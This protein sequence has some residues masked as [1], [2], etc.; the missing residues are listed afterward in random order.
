MNMDE[1]T[2]S[3]AEPR[4]EA[5][6][7]PA[8][9][10]EALPA[11]LRGERA[12][13]K[14]AD[15]PALAKS[16]LELDRFRGRAVVPPG[17]DATP[18]DRA[19]FY[20]RMGRPKEAKDYR[21]EMEGVEVQD[22]AVLEQYLA[23]FHE[24]GLTDA[25]VSALSRFEAGRV[26]AAGEAR[27][28]AVAEQWTSLEAEW[29]GERDAQLGHARRAASALGLEREELDRIADASGNPLGLMRALVKLGR[30]FAEDQAPG[31]VARDGGEGADAIQ[32]RID[33]LQSG[34]L[35]QTQ[36]AQ[37]HREVQALYRKLY[38]AEE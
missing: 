25:Q 24:M 13:E 30:G 23:T 15:V 3:D 21:L 36:D 37:T 16:F 17:K 9:W 33:A 14:F 34:R 5:A 1:T 8:N 35:Y 4:A 28:R 32:K 18:E 7:T 2:R 22:P 38:P 26:R 20:E 12:L 11:E 6:A 27:A 19:R 29:G 31:R 10:R